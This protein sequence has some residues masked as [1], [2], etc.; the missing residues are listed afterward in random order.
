[1]VMFDVRAAMSAILDKTSLEDV[2]TRVDTQRALLGK[3]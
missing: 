2:T 3:K 1:M